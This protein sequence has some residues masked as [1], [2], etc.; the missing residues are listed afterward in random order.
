MV[1]VIRT[2]NSYDTVAANTFFH[3]NIMDGRFFTIPFRVAG[4]ENMSLFNVQITSTHINQNT[5]PFAYLYAYI[6]GR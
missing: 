2:G 6:Y 1:V 3:T 5:I 4:T